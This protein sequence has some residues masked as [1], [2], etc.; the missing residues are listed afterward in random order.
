MKTTKAYHNSYTN[1]AAAVICRAIQDNDKIFLESDWC[2][3]LRDM[4]RLDDEIYG[5]KNIYDNFKRGKSY[6]IRED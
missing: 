3:L 4:C 2:A 5:A 6:E 1:L